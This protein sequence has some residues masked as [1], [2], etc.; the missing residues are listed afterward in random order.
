MV[1]LPDATPLL[2]LYANRRRRRLQALDPVATQRDLLLRLVRR[3]A[4][5]RFGRD[6]DFGGIRTVEDFQARVPL[7]RYEDFW[8]D[9]WQPA[10][11]HCH[12]IGWPGRVPFLAVSSG[13]TAGTSKY[14]PCTG[15][16]LRMHRRSAL[17]V[18]VHHLATGPASRVFGGKSFM[19]GGSTAFRREAPG[20]HSG[21]L[22][23]IVA[24]TM[25]RWARPF[26][27][28]PRHIAHL[29]DWDE[30]LEVLA[31]Q[32]RRQPIRM[33]SGTPSWLLVLMERVLA[34]N[35]AD[36]R[37]G[38]PF[39]GLDLLI[40]GG[41]GFGGYHD[42]F[43]AMVGPDV[44]FREVYPASE[45]FVAV[46]DR[47]FGD[48]LRM[49]L[50]TGIF[51]EFVPLDRLDADTPPRHWIGTVEPGVNYALVLST[52]A[53]LWG[54]V[55]GDTVRLVDTAPPRLLITGRTAAM[56]EAFG[57]R[58]I[59]EELEA[60]V[61]AGAVAAGV[62]VTDFSAGAVMP[63]AGRD[64]GHHLFVVEWAAPPAAPDAARAAFAAAMDARLADLNDDFRAHRTVM[65]PPD[66]RVVPPGTFAAW[67][68]AR[69]RAGGQNK[70]PRV[71]LRQDLL[72]DLTAF[73]D[74]AIRAGAPPG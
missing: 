26:A 30:K 56:L 46:A 74:A 27:Y 6:H 23:G 57:E 35:A 65:D 73:A 51:F 72:D 28:P 39:P 47:G 66:I 36:G 59:I 31:Q 34:L 12:D 2:R 41:T 60:G 25:P 8:R 16:I 49:Q 24:A 70:V 42:R 3:A 52:C 13:T 20:V 22:S 64:R 29:S 58:L 17:D 19:V 5:T 32:S 11:P 10:F 4:G 45:G 69:G 40:H 61:Q 48:G 37:G 43:R 63:T 53:G 67:M 21:D 14:L 50:D 7:R 68:K 15:D 54:Y 71:I 1:A 18:L 38:P 33:I 44:D 62:Q 9:Y 55:I